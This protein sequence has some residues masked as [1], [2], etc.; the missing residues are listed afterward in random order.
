MAAISEREMQ[1][2][3]HRI[4]QL[5]KLQG[6]LTT[7]EMSQELKI[8]YMGVRQHL[9]PAV[10]DGLIRYHTEQRGVGRPTYVYSLT[11][12]GDEL[13]PRTYPPLANN[14]LAPRNYPDR[15]PSLYAA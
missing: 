6:P 15:P 13:F 8:T 1:D 10:H 14:L 3:R 5:L 2:T 7:D 9:T 11:E 4:L 12:L